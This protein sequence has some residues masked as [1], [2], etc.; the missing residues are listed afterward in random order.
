M[1]KMGLFVCL[2]SNKKIPRMEGGPSDQREPEADKKKKIF[3]ETVCARPEFPSLG[4]V[5]STFW[6]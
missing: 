6:Y 4:L 5:N 1:E 2:L 3:R